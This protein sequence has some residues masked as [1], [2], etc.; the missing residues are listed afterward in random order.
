MAEEL[1]EAAAHCAMQ[2]QA[3]QHARAAL[4]EG[5]GV[6]PLTMPDSTLWNRTKGA[7]PWLGLLEDLPFVPWSTPA[8]AHAAQGQ[9]DRQDQQHQQNRQPQGQRE[10]AGGGSSAGE[11]RGAGT[12]LSPLSPLSP[13]QRLALPALLPPVTVYELM[14]SAKAEAKAVGRP[15]RSLDRVVRL[16][17]QIVLSAEAEVWAIM[18][19]RG[20]GPPGTAAG[21]GSVLARAQGHVAAGAARRVSSCS[22]FTTP[23]AHLHHSPPRDMIA[24]LDTHMHALGRMYPQAAELVARRVWAAHEGQVP[25]AVHEAFFAVVCSL[26]EPLARF[27]LAALTGF[28][29]TA[30]STLD[31][32]A[33]AEC[34]WRHGMQGERDGEEHN[35]LPTCLPFLLLAC[36][37]QCRSTATPLRWPM[38][39]FAC[40]CGGRGARA[41]FFQRPTT[42]KHAGS[43][44]FEVGWREEAV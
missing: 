25:A 17:T 36:R 22:P 8:A 39:S 40:S 12:A 1:R 37:R 42:R 11:G 18:R 27:Q 6:S 13:L 26:S 7:L 16:Q 4:R 19:V 29:D 10:Q 21:D 30:T 23:Q 14:E 28:D 38:Q 41:P 20:A 31:V 5:L 43:A 2:G 33:T 24:V 44:V 35:L 34:A 3:A 9:P 32:S 15:G